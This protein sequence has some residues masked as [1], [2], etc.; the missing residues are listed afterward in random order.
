MAQ[1]CHDQ[2][3]DLRTINPCSASS[4]LTT[5]R[6]KS[7]ASLVV[8]P[9]P[10]APEIG[11]SQQLNGGESLRRQ[12]RDWCQ[13]DGGDADGNGAEKPVD[14]HN[15]NERDNEDCCADRNHQGGREREAVSEDIKGAEQRR[16]QI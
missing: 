14:E 12:R 1:E 16:P 13:N 9:A 2:S 10:A 4:A 8:A 11:P 6:D 3:F 5:I 7:K 15:E